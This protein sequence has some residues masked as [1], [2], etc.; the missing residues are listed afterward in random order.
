MNHGAREQADWSSPVYRS[1]VEKIVDK[2]AAR[3]GKN[4]VV[5]G[6]QIDNE[7]SHYGQGMSYGAPAQVK[8]REWLR[9]KFGTI[10]KLN[11]D[12]GTTFW[13]QT[14][15]DFSQVQMPN[16]YEL[17]AGANPHAMLDLH[18]WFEVE[19]ADYLRFQAAVLRRN[20]QQQWITTNFMMNY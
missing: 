13:S 10:A 18:R 19:A 11:K 7:L 4:P 3:Y 12:W 6:W 20:V 1:Y 14:Y 5:V 15:N 16:Q 8:F 9:E 2:M 17:I